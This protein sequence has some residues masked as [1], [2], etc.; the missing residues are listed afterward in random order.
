MTEARERRTAA[1]FNFIILFRK[2]RQFYF[3]FT[4]HHI[5]KYFWIRRRV[6]P[7][8][9]KRTADH[10][11][12]GADLKR[13][14]MRQSRVIGVQPRVGGSAEKG[15]LSRPLHFRKENDSAECALLWTGNNTLPPTIEIEKF[16]QVR[17]F[18]SEVMKK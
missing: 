11:M 18:S 7:M 16:A 1:G 5:I 3:S 4:S 12:S 2:V 14:R 17:L 10:Q 15:M 8:P 9:P 6:S 13:A